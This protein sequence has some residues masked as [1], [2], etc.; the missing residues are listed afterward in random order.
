MPKHPQAPHV[1]RRTA[2][3]V[4]CALAPALVAA[5]PAGAVV[6]GQIAPDGA[7]PWLAAVLTKDAPNAFA[8]QFCG[9]TVIAARRVLTAAHCVHRSKPGQ[10]AVLIGRTRLTAGGGRRIAVTSIHVDPQW[11]HGHKLGLDAAVLGLAAEAGVPP[12]ALATGAQSGAWAAGTPAWTAGWGA[13]SG[14]DSPG[15]EIYYADRLRQV[16]EPI[17]SDDACEDAYGGGNGDIVYRPAWSV[18][19]GTGAGDAGTCWGDSGGPLVVGGDGAWL[20]VG[21]VQGG[22]GC[23]S[24]GYYDVFARADAVRA[25]ALGRLSRS[26]EVGGRHRR[27]RSIPWAARKTAGRAPARHRQ[28]F[29]ARS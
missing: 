3:A 12:V 29:A 8:G 18:C 2:L 26:S 4:A 21:I 20:Q 11:L 25:F 23:A 16:S 13:L 27:G 9:G 5:Q 28:L 19:A 6:G 1:L 14:E 22:D 24:R 7:W 15:G 17:V 10:L